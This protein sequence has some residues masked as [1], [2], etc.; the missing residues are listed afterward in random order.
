[1][2]PFF[3]FFILCF[4]FGVS[5][6]QDTTRIKIIKKD[7]VEKRNQE[8][9]SQNDQTNFG[10][11]AAM[12]N[13]F[14]WWNWVWSDDTDSRVSKDAQVDRRVSKGRL[15]FI[16]QLEPYAAA[17][18]SLSELETAHYYNLGLD[19]GTEALK[20][21]LGAKLPNHSPVGDK[22]RT[23]F[24]A[25]MF[26]GISFRPYSRKKANLFGAPQA[27]F[28]FGS[29]YNFGSVTTVNT[30][31]SASKKIDYKYLSPFVGVFHPVFEKC[32]LGVR[33]HRNASFNEDS[34]SYSSL[35][36]QMNY[37]I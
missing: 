18:F 25:R 31:S 24:S 22:Q 8:T 21:G 3:L 29:E 30:E 34:P 35:S 37:S 33:L 2:K 23:L 36:F 17:E 11:G 14:P 26:T 4:C 27:N 6:A 12:L 1:M 7:Q 28:Q 5:T 13:F 9:D 32:M 16:G 20:I 15:E 19:L 10:T